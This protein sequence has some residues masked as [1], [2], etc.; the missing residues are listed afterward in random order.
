MQ[1]GY[2][3]ATE[4]YGP[5]ELIRQAVAAEAAG[6]DFVEMSDH[7]HPWL[8]DQGHSA[9]TWSVLGAIAAKTER[10]GLVTG[11]TCPS[12]RY[13]PAIVAQAAATMALVSE[14]RFVLGVGSGERLNEHVIGR[15]WPAVS[16]RHTMFREA[17]EIIRLLWQ[18]GYRSYE[19]KYL[20]LEDARVFDLP[21]EQP[22]I[23]VA[24]S[25]AASARIAAELG[26]ALFATEEKPEIVRHYRQAGG[27]GPGYAE[28]PM[29]Y[30]ADE[31]E[32]VRSALTYFRWALSGWKVMSEL[33]NPVNFEAATAQVREEDIR[34]RFACGN[35]PARYLEVAR[36]FA[37]A[38]YDRLVLMN[39]GP[40]PR[41]FFDFCEAELLG[42]LRQLGPA[43][44]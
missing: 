25:G 26:D 39:A 20:R 10:I 8:D 37:D 2:K 41:G 35:D 13:H 11:V 38:G 32:A 24:A 16:E 23:A 42:R 28:V 14:G 30:A 43:G 27:T 5:Q 6:F 4:Q 31:K 22:L 9:F 33:P 21:P 44:G 34:G 18:G 40:N 15:G 19:G 36:P 3:L 29:S 12:M 1:I 17:L 7:Y